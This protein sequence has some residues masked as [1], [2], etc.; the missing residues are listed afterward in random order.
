MNGYDILILTDHRAHTPENSLY[1][2]ASALATH[3]D[4][5]SVDIASRNIEANRGFF[6][7]DLTR[8][9]SVISGSPDLT[10]EK[11]QHLFRKGLDENALEQ[12]DFILLRLP[13]PYPPKLFDALLNN[14][15]E[16]HIINNP[17]GI[18][19]TSTKAFLLE[20][21][22]LCPPIRLL[23]T[24]EEMEEMAASYPLIL[25][26]LNS[27]G[28]QGL[29][30]VGRPDR[31]GQGEVVE[32]AEGDILT[33]DALKET[34]TRDVQYLGMKFM[35][36]VSAGDKRTVV[37]NGEVIGSSLRLPPEGSWLCNVSQGGTSVSAQPDAEDLH[38]ARTLTPIL[39]KHGVIIFGFDTLMDDDGKRKLS[40]LN[41]TSIGGIAQIC[42][43]SGKKVDAVAKLIMD[44]I[45]AVWY[46]DA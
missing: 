21:A 26:P 7:G 13:P 2:L 27:Y 36:N 5:I 46:G 32:T 9:V 24:Y 10:F 8:P 31:E 34:W 16:D 14:F 39:K 33:R 28:G 11:A 37:V 25:K 6:D 12:Y 35:K 3:E 29:L 30:R 41:T 22:D 42:I 23:H 18:I 15:T 38:I 20:V 1:A 44:H 43:Q 19:R 4:T 17:R 45:N 40:E